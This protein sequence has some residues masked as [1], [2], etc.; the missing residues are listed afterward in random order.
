MSTLTEQDI[1]K[2]SVKAQNLGLDRDPHFM[3][4]FRL[5]ELNPSDNHMRSLIV[6]SLSKA[7]EATRCNP[8]SPISPNRH[9]RLDGELVVGQTQA[10]TFYGIDKNSLTRHLAVFGATGSGKTSVLLLLAIQI[11]KGDEQCL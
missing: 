4:L 8:L 7:E 6:E 9:D 3:R 2:L 11:L 5:L 10:G 1:A